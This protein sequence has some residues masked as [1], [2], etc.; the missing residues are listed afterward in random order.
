MSNKGKI[1]KNLLS[2]KLIDELMNSGG[3][4]SGVANIA[5]RKHNE[6]ITSNTNKIFIGTEHFTNT[7]DTLLVF[8]NSVYLEND[9]DYTFNPSDKTISRADGHAWEASS[10]APAIFF[11]ICLLNVPTGDVKFDGSKILDDTISESKLSQEVKLKLNNVPSIT[12]KNIPDNTIE[13]SKLN[14]TL[15]DKLNRPTGNIY[16]KFAKD[17]TTENW[18]SSP[19]TDEMYTCRIQHNLKTEDIIL[20]AINKDTKTNVPISYKIIDNNNIEIEFVS[21]DRLRILCYAL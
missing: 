5:I 16:G 18:S 21:R 13:E 20:S 19:N 7:T 3:G 6:T 14:K 10:E 12:N 11:F 1:R 15:R 2:P 9:V 17:I 4:G 8:R